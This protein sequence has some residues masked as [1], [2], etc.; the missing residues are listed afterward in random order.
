MKTITL[1]A[2][3]A[4]L[5]IFGCK[6]SE[7]TSSPTIETIDTSILVDVNSHIIS[8]EL[9]SIDNEMVTEN[10]DFVDDDAEKSD[11][12]IDIDNIDMITPDG[13]NILKD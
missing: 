7:K 3:L 2:I 10:V 11:I 9:K 1:I 8:D 12:I 13:V 6:S 4:M 5:F